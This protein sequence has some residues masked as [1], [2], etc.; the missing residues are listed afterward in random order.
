MEKEIL[1]TTLLSIGD[2]MVTTDKEG[3][4][5]AMNMV[6][7]TI[8][9]WKQEEARGRFFDEVFRLVNEE[10]GQEVENP[11]ARVLQ[12][13]KIIGLANHTLLITE[14]GGIIPIA[15]SAAPIKDEKDDVYG[16][17]MVFRDV[18]KER[19]YHRRFCA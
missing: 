10:T 3:R 7:E 1:K 18:T 15:D 2:G 4:I 11:V 9:G 17:V 16:V 6:A 12:T 19:E 14:Q 5:T 8:T 13:G